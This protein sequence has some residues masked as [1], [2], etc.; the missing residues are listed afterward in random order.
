MFEVND[1]I[2]SVFGYNC[3]LVN[4]YRVIGK[5]K[6]GKSVKIQQLKENIV[7]HDGY[8]QAGFVRPSDELTDEKPMTVRTQVN[9]FG[10]DYVKINNHKYGYKWDGSNVA[11]DTYD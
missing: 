8:G 10:D 6:S 4:F 9:I 5:T 2:V 1:V 11:F 7:S 3:R